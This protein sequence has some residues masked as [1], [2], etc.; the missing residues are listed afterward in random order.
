MHVEGNAYELVSMVC[1]GTDLY[2][3]LFNAGSDERPKQ[4][5]FQADVTDAASVE[6]DKRMTESLPVIKNKGNSSVKLSIPEMGI[7]TLKLTLNK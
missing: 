5:S 2:I 6:L 7:R 3:R 4:I 1:E